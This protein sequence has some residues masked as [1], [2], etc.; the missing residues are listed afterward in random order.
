MPSG[1][2]A[3]FGVSSLIASIIIELERVISVRNR[4]SLQVVVACERKRVTGSLITEVCLS[5]VNHHHALNVLSPGKYVG[6]WGS[7][8]TSDNII[9]GTQRLY[10]IQGC[11]NRFEK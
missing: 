9:T 2:P 11:K 3:E 6:G 1:P 10:C 4:S 7:V 8:V 5:F